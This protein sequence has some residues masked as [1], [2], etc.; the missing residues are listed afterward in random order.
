MA[1]T[2]NFGKVKLVY[3]GTYS[4]TQ[5]YSNGDIVG[6]GTVTVGAGTTNNQYFIYKNDTAKAGSFPYI[7]TCVGIATIG[8]T[9]NIIDV[10]ISETNYGDDFNY[11]ITPTL[12]LIHSR[13]FPFNTKVSSKTKISSN[14]V[15]IV[16]TKKSTNTLSGVGTVSSQNIVI[17]PRRISNRYDVQR[18]TVDWDS[19][20]EGFHFKGEFSNTSFYDMGDIVTYNDQSYICVAPIGSGN[21][22]M[23]GSGLGPSTTTRVPDPNMDMIGVWDPFMNS[24]RLPHQRAV[25]LP[26]TEP[27]D[28]KGHPY[29]DPPTWGNTG[30]GSHYL[31]STPWTLQ[32]DIKNNKNS[33]RWN[34]TL[35]R[36]G[37]TYGINQSFIDGDGNQLSNVGRNNDSLSASNPGGDSYTWGTFAEGGS[38]SLRSYMTDDNPSYGGL[39]FL[40]SKNTIKIIQYLRT[41]ACHLYLFS[42]GSVGISGANE[43]HYGFGNVVAS[44]SNIVKELPREVFDGE[45]IVKI[46]GFEDSTTQAT[47]IAH[48]GALDATGELWVWGTN[49]HGHLGVGTEQLNPRE[50]SLGITTALAW[51]IGHDH[52]VTTDGTVTSPVRLNR[53]SSF[54]GRRIV[55]FAMGRKASYALD[56]DGQLWAWGD[57]GVGQLGYS[58]VDGFNATDRSRRPRIVEGLGYTWTG[59]NFVGVVT[60]TAGNITE[61]VA[62]DTYEK[63]AGGSSYNA[64]VVGTVGY[65]STVVVS[66]KPLL[67]T[68]SHQQFG[69]DEDPLTS[70]GN[71]VTYAWFYHSNGLLYVYINGSAQSIP[72]NYPYT[73]STV[74]S[75]VYDPATGFIEWYYDYDGTGETVLLVYRVL[76]TKNV[77]AFDTPLYFDSCI[78]HVG[79][80]L[81]NIRISDSLTAKTWNDYGG[82]Q[83]FTTS[84]H[85][86]DENYLTIL[87]GHGYI[88]NC[89]FNGEGQLGDGYTPAVTYLNTT[90]LQRRNFGSSGIKGRINNFWMASAHKTFFSVQS[91]TDP[92]HNE[93]WGVGYNGDRGLTTGNATDQTEPVRI[94]GPRHRDGVGIT[95]YVGD[96]VTMVTGF[97]YGTADYNLVFALDKYGY[98]YVFGNENTGASGAIADGTDNQIITNN[99]SKV[100]QFDVSQDGWPRVYMPNQFQGKCI[101][102]W[103]TGDHLA[104]Y[105]PDVQ[106]SLFLMDDGYILGCGSNRGPSTGA[107]YQLGAYP[108]SGL[109]MRTPIPLSGLY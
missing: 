25:M 40:E 96:I 26:G 1:S 21:N 35:M 95:T 104:T 103:T 97:T 58:T 102:I 28:W 109:S 73:T 88:W 24:D 87:D 19:Y 61:N 78:Y 92:T 52:A 79:G 101:D 20:S 17:G 51:G 45:S 66:A 13:Y 77:S 4:K 7:R 98:V 32:D 63:T 105:Y 15:R 9:T 81:V 10:T 91:S 5:S 84:A 64:E 60:F 37:N 83:K 2:I 46:S 44:D 39:S 100:Q 82:I 69:L 99:F 89:G 56:E 54:G 42:N 33:W 72:T 76:K 29:I 48:F 90:S 93:L 71:T 107:A 57:N 34:T 18:N 8:V 23:F 70:A 67:A 31:G 14:V 94:H 49:D 85:N 16:T 68:G 53:Y 106:A 55:D 3:K 43:V 86:G 30:I 6:F 41:Y 62:G 59:S 50:F 38:F 65:A 36:V 80:G 27:Y 11:Q 74:C 22:D 12:S 75:I 47:G 108:N